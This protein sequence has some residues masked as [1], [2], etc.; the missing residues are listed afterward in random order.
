MARVKHSTQTRHKS[1]RSI[2]II[3]TITLMLLLAGGAVSMIPSGKNYID[4]PQIKTTTA[5]VQTKA[6]KAPVKHDP[7]AKPKPQ[8]T[9]RADPPF[10]EQSINQLQP[11]AAT[12]NLMRPQYHVTNNA[13]TTYHTTMNLTVQSSGLIR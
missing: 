13:R 8:K 1:W 12:F 10:S 6:E 5:H 3:S 11:E 9:Q 7:Q 4:S 2:V